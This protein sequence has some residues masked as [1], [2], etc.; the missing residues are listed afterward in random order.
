MAKKNK[1]N[2]K[3]EEQQAPAAPVAASVKEGVLEI[4]VSEGTGKTPNLT[5]VKAKPVTA[6]ELAEK[7]ASANAAREAELEK[8]SA[9]AAVNLDE[10]K[11]R[12]D[13]AQEEVANKAVS[14][15]LKEKQAAEQAAAVLREKAAKA[16][17]HNRAVAEAVA[18]ASEQER[19]VVESVAEK[20]ATREREAALRAA[21]HVD[22]KKEAA[23]EHNRAVA[24]AVARASSV[25]EQEAALVAQRRLE[26]EAEV[27]R[28]ASEILDA[29]KSSAFEHNKAVAETVA[30]TLAA[31]REKDEARRSET[32]ALSAPFAEL[33]KRG[34]VDPLPE[35]EK[36]SVMRRLE[37]SAER[38]APPLTAAQLEESLRAAERNRESHLATHVVGKNAGHVDHVKAVANDVK[39]EA[40]A[41]AER[42]AKETDE[43][44]LSAAQRREEALRD[45]QQPARLSLAKRRKEFA[46]SQPI[47]SILLGT[48][49]LAAFT[50]GILSLFKDRALRGLLRLRFGSR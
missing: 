22:G 47:T 31:R 27:A 30:S 21:A 36:P 16:S 18:R 39:E 14:A 41:K 3:A 9:R 17:E 13:L 28:K 26:K 11:A 32:E 48:V 49:V 8:I 2:H 4:P 20:Q 6:A 33:N 35:S 24:E 5:P 15:S 42:L 23:A 34:T 46:N 7:L 44:L 12:R 50:A 45:R 43:R 1:N 37:A 38:K 10:A 40:K 19:E 25:E 29:K